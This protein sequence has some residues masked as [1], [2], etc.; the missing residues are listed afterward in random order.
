M[1]KGHPSRKGSASRDYGMELTLAAEAR[2]L[3]ARERWG[4]LD[5]LRRHAQPSRRGPERR[6]GRAPTPGSG[7]DFYEFDPCTG[8]WR[9][10]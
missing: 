5:R 4:I 9:R 10:L 2:R 7:R 8:Q 3:P 1:H 6:P